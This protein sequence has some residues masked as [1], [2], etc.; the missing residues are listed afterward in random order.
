MSIHE[1]MPALPR[2][3][4]VPRTFAMLTIKMFFMVVLNYSITA[5]EWE[6]STWLFNAMAFAPCFLGII[7]QTHRVGP[8]SSSSPSNIAYLACLVFTTCLMYVAI[9]ATTRSFDEK[10]GSLLSSRSIQRCSDGKGVLNHKSCLNLTW[11]F[12]PG[13][14]TCDQILLDSLRD[15]ANDGKSA[16]VGRHETSWEHLFFESVGSSLMDHRGKGSVV[17]ERTG[18]TYICPFTSKLPVFRLIFSWMWNPLS[19]MMWG[20]KFFNIFLNNVLH[21]MM[22]QNTML[23]FGMG[24]SMGFN[25]LQWYSGTTA[26]R[27]YMNLILRSLSDRNSLVY[28]FLLWAVGYFFPILVCYF[29]SFQVLMWMASAGKLLTNVLYVAM[30]IIFTAGV[31]V[32]HLVAAPETTLWRLELMCC[33]L[34]LCGLEF[35]RPELCTFFY[36]A[37]VVLCKV[38][39]NCD[40]SF[41]IPVFSEFFQKKEVHGILQAG[42]ERTGEL[43]TNTLVVVNDHQARQIQNQARPAPRKAK[44]IQNQ[45]QPAPKRGRKG[46]AVPETNP[47][48]AETGEKSQKKRKR[49][50]GQTEPRN[51]RHRVVE[52]SVETDDEEMDDRIDD[53]DEDC[54]EMD[55]C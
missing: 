27:V 29:V 22:V 28:K 24:G 15:F 9:N 19:P 34:R 3:H 10:M 42:I 54:E 36:V 13:P 50:Q 18:D 48:R 30:C 8:E 2:I 49:D 16:G 25:L 14:Q 32:T 17:P 55:D 43:V 46:L 33:F 52:S 47:T 37:A 35:V 6:H 41:E 40:F 53:M 31:S 39:V 5:E 26:S 7:K 23:F 45:A 38:P 1:Q 12:E 44:Q 20:K 21:P 4:T 51:K 11:G